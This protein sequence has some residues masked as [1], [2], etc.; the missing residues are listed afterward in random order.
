MDF[1]AMGIGME[2]QS[3]KKGSPGKRFQ[4]RYARRKKNRQDRSA[5]LRIA[6][7]VL[8]IAII[9]VG[10]VLVPAPGPGWVV[11]FLGLALISNEIHWVAVV[12]DWAEVKL[13]AAFGWVRSRFR[14]RKGRAPAGAA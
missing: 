10:L 7:M 13:R 9:L 14:P 1:N 2:W 11:V 3:L 8:G 12:L 4:D 6:K 5:V